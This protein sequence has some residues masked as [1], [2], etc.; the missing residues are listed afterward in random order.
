MRHRRRDSGRETGF[1]TTDAARAPPLST[2][3]VSMAVL[4]RRRCPQWSRATQWRLFHLRAG[5]H[6]AVVG[7][8]KQR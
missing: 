2:I 5:K 4:S 6:K 3:I 8:K 7:G 1:F